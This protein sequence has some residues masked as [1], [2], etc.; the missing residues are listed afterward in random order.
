MPYILIPCILTFCHSDIL[1]SLFCI[2]SLVFCILYSV[3]CD[4]LSSDILCRHLGFL[5][6]AL[7]GRSKRRPRGQTRSMMMMITMMM[8]KMMMMMMMTIMMT[9]TT[10]TTTMMMM[11]IKIFKHFVKR[12]IKEPTKIKL[13]F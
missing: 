5:C 12:G 3:Y 6:L 9:M 11:M 2:L 10:M 1:Y 4:D 13:H 8:M 7:L